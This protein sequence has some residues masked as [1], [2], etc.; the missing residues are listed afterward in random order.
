M[1]ASASEVREWA[2]ANGIAV[3]SRGRFPASVVA[4]FNKGRRA[5]KRYAEPSAA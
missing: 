3:G 2:N 4:A 5:P 1:S